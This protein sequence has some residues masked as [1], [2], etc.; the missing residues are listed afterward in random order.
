MLISE[1]AP[2]AWDT[3]WAQLAREEAIPVREAQRAH[4]L[5]I[6]EADD[7]FGRFGRGSLSDRGRVLI[8]YAEPTRFDR[9]AGD[10][11]REQQWE[12]WYY[13]GLG[14]RFTFVDRHGLGDY[15]LQETREY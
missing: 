6:I 2:A 10:S 8:R 5:R 9:H 1:I 7:R 13:S 15:R 3:V 4:L 14:L 11:A 12:V